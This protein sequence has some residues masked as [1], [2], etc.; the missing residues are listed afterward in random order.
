M[1]TNKTYKQLL[2]LFQ[3]KKNII[4]MTP[5]ISDEL[6]I[7]LIQLNR[8]VKKVTNKYI[9]DYQEKIEEGRLKFCLRNPD[10]SKVTGP[11][12][13]YLFSAEKELEFN[14][15]CKEILNTE[16]E[17][18]FN[19]T[20]EYSELFNILPEKVKKFWQWEDVEEYLSPFYTN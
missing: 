17:V 11:N 20:L 19:T 9:E 2:E 3:F 12:G 1:K 15:Y 4:Q 14:K 8:L 10:Q 13:E 18:D 6:A 5:D 7:P 16:V